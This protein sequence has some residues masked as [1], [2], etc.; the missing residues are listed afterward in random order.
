MSARPTHETA[1]SLARRAFCPGSARLERGMLDQP[2]F[3]SQ[4]GDRVHAALRVRA[5]DGG[6]SVSTDAWLGAND[7]EQTCIGILARR[8]ADAVGPWL[9]DFG[10]EFRVYREQRFTIEPDK[11][12]AQLDVVYVWEKAAI[13]LDYKTGWGDVPDSAEN[14]QLLGQ[15]AAFVSS[16]DAGK[17]PPL[18]LVGIVQ[19][20]EPVSLTGYDAEQC[21]QAIVE[22]LRIIGETE[23]ANAPLRPGEQQCKYCKAAHVCP[24]LAEQAMALARIAPPDEVALMP[25]GRMAVTLDACVLAERYVDAIRAEARRRLAAGDLVPGWM[26]EPGKKVRTVTDAQKALEAVAPHGVTVEQVLS[27]VEIGVGALEAEFRKATGLTWKKTTERLNEAL[28]AAGCLEFKQNAPSLQR[29]V[30]TH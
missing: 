28:T 3:D 9:Q 21:Q 24:A 2:T 11:F 5:S 23:A 15:V 6:P 8:E 25:P 1:S 14:H 30:A 29:A 20:G 22:V 16:F 27:C 12:S 18:V 26:L 7:E 10:P 17:E 4:R 19:P 13:I